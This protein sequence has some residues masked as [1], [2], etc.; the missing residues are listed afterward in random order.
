M[1]KIE[2]NL[3]VPEEKEMVKAL[4]REA[5]L[6]NYRQPSYCGFEGALDPKLGC[7]YIYEE[8]FEKHCEKCPCRISDIPAK[9]EPIQESNEELL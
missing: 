5:F 4:T 3:L 1:E 9:T 8:N 6:R 2:Y 7:P